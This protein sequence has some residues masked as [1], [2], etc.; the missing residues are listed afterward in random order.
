MYCTLPLLYLFKC[1]SDK[2]C[3]QSGQGLSQ[4][5]YAHTGVLN[6]LFYSHLLSPLCYCCSSCCQHHK[7]GVQTVNQTTAKQFGLIW[8]IFGRIFFFLTVIDTSKSKLWLLFAYL[9]KVNK[10]TASFALFLKLNVHYVNEWACK[11][12]EFFWLTLGLSSFAAR[13]YF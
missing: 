10:R 5:Y 7:Q 8:F 11:G 2:S 12:L 4:S 13:K 3:I 1:T 9:I 6:T